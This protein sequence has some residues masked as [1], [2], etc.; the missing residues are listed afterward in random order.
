MAKTEHPMQAL[1][2]FLP[3]NSFE[4]VVYYLNYYKAELTIT[5]KRKTLLGAYRNATKDKNHR[6]SVN[7]NLNPYDFLITLLH[8]LAHLLVFEK[9]GHHIAAHGKEW[10]QTYAGILAIFLQDQIFPQDITAA[11]YRSLKNPGASACSDV[12]LGRV[13]KKYDAPAKGVLIESLENGQIFFTTDGK[14]FIKLKKIRSRYLCM[15]INSGKQYSFS[16]LYEVVPDK[17]NIQ[18]V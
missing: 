4:Q 17:E 3:E 18:S 2:E 11:L 7:G 16:A 14:K 5:R 6:I 15:E 13:L 1:R 9:Y 12:E 10:K 8:E